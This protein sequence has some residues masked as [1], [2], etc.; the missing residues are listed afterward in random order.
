MPVRLPHVA[1]AV[2]GRGRGQTVLGQVG[3]HG[4][5]VKGDASARVHEHQAGGGVGREVAEQVGLGAARGI[6]V[7]GGAGQGAATVSV[8]LIPSFLEWDGRARRP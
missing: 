4:G 8:L 2:R 1:V 5:D 3:V 7:G 6:A